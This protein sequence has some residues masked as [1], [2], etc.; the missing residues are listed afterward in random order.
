AYTL[1]GVR[2]MSEVF[3]DAEGR[4]AVRTA[5][6]RLLARFERS[7]TLAGVLNYQWRPQ[8]NDVCVTGSAQMALIWLALARSTRD[9]RLVNAAF[10]AIDEVK[11]AQTIAHPDSGISGGVPGS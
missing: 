7:N 9:V 6:E 4:D 5:A 2:R 8:T 1:D 11:R 3:G 10:K